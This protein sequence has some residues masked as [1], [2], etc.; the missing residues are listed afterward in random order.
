M[1]FVSADMMG[2]IAPA[3]IAGM[4]VSAVH[5]PLGQEVLRRGII[6]ID[7]AIAQ[8]AALG[9]VSAGVIFHLEEGVWPFFFALLFALGGSGLFSLMEKKSPQHQEAFIGCAFVVAA[10]GILLMLA[11]HPHGGEEIEGLLAGQILWVSW[12]QIFWSAAVYAAALAAWFGMPRWRRGLF[13]GIFPV[14]IT[15]SVQLIGVY[16]VFAILI[17][18]ALGAIK[19]KECSRLA[20]AY[21]I[22]FTAIAAGLIISVLADFPAGPMIVLALAAI[23][24]A[25]VLCANV[26]KKIRKKARF[27]EAV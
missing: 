21:G 14:V 19:F 3:F 22:A 2:L 6:F 13:Y 10:C 1:S 27:I 5:V 4:I 11:N 9:V 17:M 8:I 25:S 15:I 23:S 12:S 18:P 24:L 26:C 20:I 16:L 7:L